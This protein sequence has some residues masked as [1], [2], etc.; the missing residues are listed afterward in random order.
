[1]ALLDKL[2]EDLKTAMKSGDKVRVETVR[3]LRGQLK[4]F[5]INQQHEPSAEEEVG[6]LVSAAKKRREAIEAYTK[7]GRQDLAEKEAAELAVI[8]EYL[9]KGLTQE[10]IVAIIAAAIKEVGATGAGEVGKVMGKIM[11]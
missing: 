9:P 1:M 3:L 6:V 4:D 8:S 5:R 2:S 10:E 7:A 11:S